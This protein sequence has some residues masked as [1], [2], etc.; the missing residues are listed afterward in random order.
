[1]KNFELERKF[2]KCISRNSLLFILSV[3]KIS[4]FIILKKYK[5]IWR[6]KFKMFEYAHILFPKKKNILFVSTCLV[7]KGSRNILQYLHWNKKMAIIKIFKTFI[8]F[9]LSAFLAR[10]TVWISKF[11]CSYHFVWRCQAQAVFS[12]WQV[13]F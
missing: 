7:K 2:K 11:V 12:E 3:N 8:L 4:I 1:M 10:S 6:G 13:V 5:K 9:A